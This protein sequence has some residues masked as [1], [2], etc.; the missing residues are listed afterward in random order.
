MDRYIC[1]IGKDNDRDC[2]IPCEDCANYGKERRLAERR[3]TNISFRLW[4]KREGFDRRQNREKNNG[5]YNK[6]FRRGAFHLRHNYS[7]LIVLLVLFNLFNIADYLF[8]LKA[9]AAG[10]TE[11]NPVMDRLFDMGPV[12]A[13][14]FKIATGLFITTIVWL[15]KRYRLVLE[16]SIL[17]L[18]MYMLLISYH[19]YGVIRYY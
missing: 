1:Y 19:I 15:L 9:L 8:T 3:K 12:V 10:Y 2:D 14:T 6:L 7:A 16:A 13:L 18:L 4:E 5:L 17:I 11:G